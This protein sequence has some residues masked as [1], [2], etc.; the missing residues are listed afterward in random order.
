MQLIL[1]LTESLP[2]GSSSELEVSNIICEKM[3]K[4][5]PYELI[6]TVFIHIIKKIKV[7]IKQV[8]Y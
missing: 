6:C 3:F 5:G 1:N 2:R 8:I 7:K 4:I